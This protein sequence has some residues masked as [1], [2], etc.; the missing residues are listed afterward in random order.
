MNPAP[1]MQWSADALFAK[2]RL[3][4]DRALEHTEDDEL[5]PFWASL[6][7]EFLSRAALAY[8]HPTL[9]AEVEREDD[10]RN[11]LY[12]LG[13]QPNVGKF[14]PK[15]IPLAIVYRR[16]AAVIPE[17]VEPRRKL[18]EMITS[19]RNEELHSG[20]SPFTA[21]ATSTWLPGFYDAARVLL[22]SMGK[23]LADWLGAE[24]A[25]RADEMLRA[26]GDE[27]AKQVQK[28][29]SARKTIWG[30]IDAVEQN[31]K[32][33]TAKKEATPDKGHRVDCP[34]C[35]SVALVKGDS[36]I[37]QPPKADEGGIQVKHSVLPD[38][39]WCFACGLEIRGH[40]LLYAAGLGNVYTAT[41]RYTP[42]EYYAD[43]VEQYAKE[44]YGGDGYDEYCNE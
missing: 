18:C 26:M 23:D 43:D 25:G 19:R 39:F 27:A 20:G 29:I 12:A 22:A 2:A 6:S 30:G 15:S 41:V 31:A 1:D 44:K 7:L 8:V 40:A 16:C 37:T 32:E 3:Y 38:R 34:A 42:V 10:G 14:S 11:L 5:F 24:P 35:G 36:I 17:F 9:L 13:R 33:E 4:V 21:V 28:L